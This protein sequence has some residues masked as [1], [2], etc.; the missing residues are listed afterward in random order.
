MRFGLVGFGRMG[1]LIDRMARDGGHA[2]EWIVSPLE[3]EAIDLEVACAHGADVA[4]EFTEPGVAEGNVRK[5]LQAGIPVVCGT[6][7]W[8]IP[9]DLDA[10]ARKHNV[11]F[12][13]ADNFSLGIQW[14]RRVTAMLS[15][16]SGAE[17]SFRPWI[18]ERH[19]QQKIDAPSGTARMLASVIEEA[20]PRGLKPVLLP[21]AG[22]LPESGFP[23]TATRVGVDPG[24][25]TVG[26]DGP[27]ESIQWTH[28]AR[29][30][31]GFASGAVQVSEWI[32]GRKGTFTIDA[33]LD[34]WVGE[35]SAAGEETQ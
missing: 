2:R 24:M 1:R 8:T 16:W 14:M 11:A 29:G 21:T 10:I 5:L 31:E 13:Q 33:V 12:L 30:R 18:H 6:T 22:K 4:F 7:G 9:D 34:A 35:L 28:Q 32:V 15:M 19:H 27:Y 23:V 3:D 17:G 20:D 26:W 25:H